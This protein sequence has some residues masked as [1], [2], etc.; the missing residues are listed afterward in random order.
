MCT[1]D[2]ENVSSDDDKSS[3]EEEAS[4]NET[5]NQSFKFSSA[6]LFRIR[7]TVALLK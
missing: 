2:M 7:K 3:E 1:Y 4:T 6:M 5:V